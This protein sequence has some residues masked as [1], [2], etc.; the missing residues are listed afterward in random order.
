[1]ANVEII[2]LLCAGSVKYHELSGG[3][4]GAAGVL[5]RAEL[6]GLLSGLSSEAMNFALAKYAGDLEA[7]R[8][9]ISQLRVWA[10]G[11]AN[12]EGWQI[13]RGRPTVVNMCALAAF[14][15][16]RPNRCQRCHGRGVDVSKP[17]V[18]CNGSTFRPLSGRFI[19]DAVGVSET[20]FRRLWKGRYERI[21]G[22][23]HNIDANINRIIRL[24]D[25]EQKMSSL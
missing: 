16:V 21:Y 18:V 13:V 24:S 3:G 6:A 15:V 10:V 1:M 14:E 5:S 22:R 19:A 9:F 4:G 2:G 23:V 8:S 17:C 11:V 20:D 25:Y 7:E 12:Q